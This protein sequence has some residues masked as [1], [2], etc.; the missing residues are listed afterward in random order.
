MYVVFWVRTDVSKTKRR[1]RL[2]DMAHRLSDRRGVRARPYRVG[3][4]SKA[5]RSILSWG[6][7]SHKVQVLKNGTWPKPCLESL[8]EENQNPHCIGTWTLRA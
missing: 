5:Q 2:G 8:V 7:H 1:Y 3:A 6:L 4:Y